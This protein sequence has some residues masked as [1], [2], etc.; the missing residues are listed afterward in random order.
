MSLDTDARSFQQRCWSELYNKLFVDF[1]NNFEYSGS[2]VTIRFNYKPFLHE[3]TL[4]SDYNSAI[5]NKSNYCRPLRLTTSIRK[6]STGETIDSDDLGALMI[7]ELT[8]RGFIIGGHGYDVANLFREAFGWYITLDKKYNVMMSL[9]TREGGKFIIVNKDDELFIEH[10][11]RSIGFGIFLK[12]VTE[13][14]SAS[15]VSL[16]GASSTLITNTLVDQLTNKGYELPLSECIC[17]AVW[18]TARGRKGK[19]DFRK[20]SDSKLREMLKANLERIDMGSEGLERYKKFI[21]FQR[22]SEGAVLLDDVHLTNGSVIEKDTNLSRVDLI[23]MDDDINVTEITVAYHDSTYCI[24]KFPLDDGKFNNN[25][26]SNIASIAFAVFS[27]LG[28]LDDRD[29]LENRV[30]ENVAAYIVECVNDYL[31]NQVC[32]QIDSYKNKNITDVNKLA[33]KLLDCRNSEYIVQ[34]YKKET[35][36]QLKDDVNII[37]ELSK[38][39]KLSYKKKSAKARIGDAI[40]NIKVKQFMR[41]CPIDTPESKEVGLNTYLTMT[42]GVDKN[43]FVTAS[44]VDVSTGEIVQMNALDEMGIP[45]MVWNGDLE[46]EEFVNAHIDGEFMMVHRS[47]IKYKD[48]SPMGL[49]SFSTGSVPFIENDKS[50]RALM[51]ANMNRQAVHELGS[52][53]PYV[54]T[55]ADSILDFGITRAKDIV[56][57]WAD[58]KGVDLTPEELSGITLTLE[59]ITKSK[60]G[61]GNIRTLSFQ[62]DSSKLNGIY[63]VDIPYYLAST[64]GCYYYMQVTSGQTDFKGQD[65]VYYHRDIQRDN[66]EVVNNPNFGEML[67]ISAERINECGYAL[68]RN[69]KILYKSYKGYTY[70]DA[71]VINRDL[72]ENKSLTSIYLTEIKVELQEN[73]TLKVS[74]SFGIDGLNFTSEEKGYMQ[75]NGLPA[76]GSYIRGGQT[77][78]GRVRREPNELGV[79]RIENAS[80]TLDS[81]SEGWVVDARIIYSEVGKGRQDVAVVSIAS[82]K[83]VSLGDKYVGRHGNKGVVAKIVPAEDMPFGEDGTIPD[84]VLNPLGIIAR[85]NFGQLLE[86]VLGMAGYKMNK[87]FVV[88]ALSDDNYETMQA[89]KEILK[90]DY[91]F[92]EMTVYDGETGLPYPK[93]MMFGIMHMYKLLHIADRPSK[94]IGA[95]GNAVQEV[96]QQPRNGQRISELQTNAYIAHGATETLDSFFSIQSDDIK[97]ASR[98]QKRVKEGGSSLEDSIDIQGENKSDEIVR[99]FLRTLGVD[100]ISVDGGVRFKYLTDDDILDISGTGNDNV[101]TDSSNNAILALHNEAIFGAESKK[102]SRTIG[103]RVRRR[104]NYGRIELGYSVIMPVIFRNPHFLNRFM[105]LSWS[106]K[107]AKVK[108][109]GEETEYLKVSVSRNS[110]SS[111]V[112]ADLLVGK[113]TSYAYSPKTLSI[114]NTKD[115]DAINDPELR[116]EA[117]KIMT[118]LG[119]DVNMLND[120]SR[121][122][123]FY[124]PHKIDI[125]A[126]MYRNYNTNSLTA[127]NEKVKGIYDEYQNYLVVNC[128]FGQDDGSKFDYVHTSMAVIQ[129]L[130]NPV[131]IDGSEYFVTKML[132]M[133]ASFR[134]RYTTLKG[135]RHND[136]DATYIKIIGCSNELKNHL[137]RHMPI[138]YDISR[139]YQAL[140]SCYKK[141]EGSKSTTSIADL[142]LSSN[143]NKTSTV[144]RGYVGAKR[145]AYSSRSVIAV[146]PLLHLTECGIPYKHALVLWEDNLTWA[147]NDTQ[148]VEGKTALTEGEIHKLIQY[149]VDGNYYAIGYDLFDVHTNPVEFAKEVEEIIV[150]ELSSIMKNE[151]VILNREPALHKFNNLAFIPVL[152][153]G[154]SI[155]LHP[156]VCAAYNA[157]FDGDTMSSIVCKS[158]TAK[159]EAR[160]KMTTASNIINPKDGKNI[161]AL[162]QDIVLGIYMLTMLAGNDAKEVPV[163]DRVPVAFYDSVKMLEQDVDLGY[164]SIYDYVGFKRSGLGNSKKETYYVSTAGRIIFNSLLPNY[165]GFTQTEVVPNTGVCKLAYDMR[166]NGKALNGIVIKCYEENT[167]NKVTVE[168]LDRF[169]E[170]GMKYADKSGAT[171]SVNDFEDKSTIVQDKVDSVNEEVNK[172]NLYE[173]LKLFPTSE[174]RTAVVKLWADRLKEIQGE[175]EESMDKDGSVY[176]IIDSGARGSK[177]D[178]NA[179]SG[180]I[181]QVR[182]VDN[183]VIERPI[184]GNFLK[185]LS[186]DEYF[187]STYQARRGQISTSTKTADSGTN[188]RHVSHMLNNVL[189]IEE[190]CDAEPYHLKLKWGK[191]Y[192]D[193]IP[194]IIGKKITGCRYKY[195]IGKT[196]CKEVPADANPEDYLTIAGL[197]LTQMIEL[198]LDGVSTKIARH[199]DNVHRSLLE[200][201][202]IEEDTNDWLPKNILTHI[203]YTNS[204]SRSAELILNNTALDYIERNPEEYLD[205]RLL[206]GCCSKGGVCSKCY[207]KDIETKKL[208]AVGKYIGLISAM[209]I[210]EVATQGTMNMH[211]ASA[212][213]SGMGDIATRFKNAMNAKEMVKVNR[214]LNSE[215]NELEYSVSLLRGGSFVKVA[216]KLDKLGS[217]REQGLALTDGIINITDRKTADGKSVVQIIGEN[218]INEYYIH[219]DALIVS[220]GEEVREYQPLFAPY[221]YNQIMRLDED[222]AREFFIIDFASIFM[223][224]GDGVRAIHFELIGREQTSYANVSYTV[225]ACHFHEVFPRYMSTEEISD[226]LQRRYEPAVVEVKEVKPALVGKTA[227]MDSR[228]IIANAFSDEM[229]S[230]I[231]KYCM[232][233]K[234]DSCTSPLTNLFLGKKVRGTDVKVFSTANSSQERKASKNK[235]PVISESEISELDIPED[236]E[237]ATSI[238]EEETPFD[239]D[240]SNDTGIIE[241]TVDTDS[242]SEE[243]GGLLAL[244]GLNAEEIESK[245]ESTGDTEDSELKLNVEYL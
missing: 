104:N 5:L 46:N 32:R 213:A 120:K 88:P 144:I 184:L 87:R 113:F 16:I 155:Q 18:F 126:E 68:G 194:N 58:Y 225:D 192:E 151:L 96:S 242:D 82:F 41:V 237:I 22:R 76:I 231:G 197:E 173:K 232:N 180:I 207:G 215:T 13:L 152:C 19:E 124:S 51:A 64:S 164:I 92:D 236:E 125:L 145:I 94:V 111:K 204:D 209:A 72:F 158:D 81:K 1:F 49:L 97:G 172:Y 233:G 235:K 128:D 214:T 110:V 121:K 167:N 86:C 85:G 159:R 47:Q 25:M 74:E 62:S 127:L 101:V 141:P 226:E 39:Y 188:N 139:L 56:R 153:D 117:I 69:L 216:D 195:F 27:G 34:R 136:V 243:D 219:K 165:A 114:V 227:V 98:L 55:G 54:V 99:A 174:K 170:Y 171:I 135:E 146:N 78:I 102:H 14:E 115:L 23:R 132:I 75:D 156:L 176:A 187:I 106:F 26:L 93:K 53:R 223:G 118:A 7:P 220:Q 103:N 217:I 228:D 36:V 221:D 8:P 77:V 133:P 191:L 177:S 130:L 119:Y 123:K 66:I 65:I 71:V 31:V 57:D 241:T 230:K 45:I 28:M 205:V 179:I 59:N 234:V 181:G 239:E 206:I 35:I 70:E 189:V 175:I 122:D 17:E 21:S 238:Y 43:G 169:K 240:I 38:T 79:D 4:D 61:S 67:D 6:N 30:V 168:L 80:V 105:F 224:S 83:D 190:N 73:P 42:A 182:N 148:L 203:E 140:D 196:L 90:D 63:K 131:G 9:K 52:E 186:V 199:L 198:E 178:F 89:A 185:G 147:L 166:I 154:L 50:K 245:P 10:N 2:E 15:M 244:L 11:G 142:L 3:G 137:D 161:I 201:R 222:F 100:L 143:I 60:S 44:Y 91:G 33:S 193:V 218:G 150:G 29:S 129:S 149:L 157:D 162:K 95:A 138:D 40:R 229:F 116:A 208:I 210:S 12:A 163:Q 212:S 48:V 24:K 183:S 202:V 84:M 37:S 134:P 211:H 107:T 160:E 200:G 108:S 20:I 109:E 112:V